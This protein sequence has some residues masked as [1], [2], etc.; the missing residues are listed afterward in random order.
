MSE[1]VGI[2]IFKLPFRLSEFVGNEIF[3][4]P[5]RLLSFQEDLPILEHRDVVMSAVHAQRVTCIEGETGDAH[6]Q[7]LNG[8][9]LGGGRGVITIC[10]AGGQP[11]AG[12][13]AARG[14]SA[15][16]A[17]LVLVNFVS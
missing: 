14:L 17:N 11:P 1:F 4:L 15:L 16:K 2:T 8:Q 5:F 13:S 6:H 7:T 9:S 10:P 12:L 3:K